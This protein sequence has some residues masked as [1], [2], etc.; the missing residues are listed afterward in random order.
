MQVEVRRDVMAESQSIED[1]I[2]DRTILD[3]FRET[4]E[5]TPDAEALRWKDGER[6]LSLTWRQYAE[7]VDEVAAGLHSIG[8]GSGEFAL[9]QSRHRPECVIAELGVLAAGGVPVVLYNTLPAEQIEY[10]AGHCQAS[11][12]LLEDESFLS[13]FDSIRSRL[14]ALRQVITFEAVGGEHGALA[15]INTLRARGRG[16]LQ[17]GW[18]PPQ[19]RAQD[20]A[21]VI[22]T[23]GTTGPPKGVIHTH[24]SVLFGVKA[25]CRLAPLQD[26][27]PGLSYLPLAHIA[28]QAMDCWVPIMVGT[29]V[30]FCPDPSLL[31]ACLGEVRPGAVFGVPR[32][33]EKMH[34][35]LTAALAA[36]PDAERREGVR[37]AIEAGRQAVR[38]REGGMPLPNEVAAG[39][40]RA[41]QIGGVLLAKLGLE[42]C[43]LAVTGGAPI[44]PH[45]VEF[46]KA[47]SLPMLEVW[48][49]SE[50]IVGTS[51]STAEGRVGTVGKAVPGVELSV[52]DDGELLIRGPLMMSGYYRDPEQTSR[53]IDAD[54]WLHTGDIATIDGDGYVRI[55][56]RIKELIITA[57]GKNMSPANIEFLLKSHP[58]VGQACVIGDRRPYVTALI[59][60]D[61]EMAPIWAKRHGIE[62]TS[63]ADL[64][65]DSQVRA[66]VERAVG[67]ANQHLA[68]VEQVKRFK[69][70]GSEWTPESGELTPTLK[71]RR[72]VISERYLPEIESLYA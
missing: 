29:A 49:M 2:A 3:V 26:Y 8:F 9:I 56:D 12:A 24:H 58:L 50:V 68:R 11:V 21:I 38:L 10:I 33:W 15:T 47:L 67:E 51:S 48:G 41:R 53:T 70:L 52:A 22:Y 6:W 54:G 1:E 27:G 7:A 19:V 46:F 34:A 35:G 42:R 37:K 45:I 14:T 62:A 69:V 18:R 17:Q 60:L 16:E 32:V 59:V 71:L 55:V 30:A 31:V 20:P 4:A 57:G 36:E 63:I 44:D 25:V 13:R 61:S 64:A 39:A 72:R 28:A 40:E 66:E 23:S 43:Q 65:E 5:R